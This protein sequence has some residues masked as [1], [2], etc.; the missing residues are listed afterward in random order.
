MDE[1]A[2]LEHE[3]PLQEMCSQGG[4]PQE[5]SLQ[6]SVSQVREL[7]DEVLV[8][9][10]C[11]FDEAVPTGCADIQMSASGMGEVELILV[12]ASGEAFLIL[13]EPEF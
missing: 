2:Q 6:L 9:I 10:K 4:W 11:F 8:T 5:E 7:G 13:P 12:P 1:L 3:L